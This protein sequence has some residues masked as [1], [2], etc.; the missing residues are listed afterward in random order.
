M[1]GRRPSPI[2]LLGTVGFAWLHEHGG[3]RFDEPFFMD[4]RCRLDR[5]QAAARLVARRFPNDPIYCFESCLVQVEGRRRPLA[6]VGAI[7]PNLILGAAV[8]AKFVFYGD[9]DA[10][11]TPAPLAGIT[12]LTPLRRIDWASTWPIDLFLRQVR[13]MR[14]ELPSDYAIVPPFFWDTTGRATIHGV[15]TTAQKLVGEQVFLDI[16]DNPA[17][18][19]ELFDWI[20]DA[21]ARLVRLFADA[22]GMR[23]TGLHV[24]ECSA[25]ML[26][27][28]AFAELVVPPTNKLVDSLREAPRRLPFAAASSA[29]DSGQCGGAGGQ[30]PGSSGGTPDVRSSAGGHDAGPPADAASSWETSP[31][32]SPAPCE[33]GAVGSA[34]ARFG[35]RLHSCGHSDHL[36]DAAAGL[37]GLACLNLGSGTSVSRVRRRLGDIR[38]DLIPDPHLLTLAGPADVDAWARRTLEENAGG[39]LEFQ[40]HLDAGQPEA[41]GHQIARTLRG[42]GIACPR[43]TVF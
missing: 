9:K 16:V 39:R 1:H 2:S 32:V 15:L 17:F 19:R 26:G 35:L 11:I 23:I 5:E 20:A 27:P 43:E 10:D 7:Q 37:N 38:I 3:L 33:R 13:Q 4:P 30:A 29:A 34:S 41:N 21:Y 18:V 42:L 6:L 8:G 36:L 31:P 40:F 12:D 22:A 24:G 14:A 25:C 28:D